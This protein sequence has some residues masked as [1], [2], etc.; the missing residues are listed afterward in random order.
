MSGR[1][2]KIRKDAKIC[3][4]SGNGVGNNVLPPDS[5]ENGVPSRNVVTNQ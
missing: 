2:E 5:S 3:E 4:K 1:S